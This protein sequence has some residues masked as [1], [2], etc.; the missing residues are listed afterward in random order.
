M[1]DAADTLER[2]ERKGLFLQEENR[3]REAPLFRENIR[4]MVEENG[5]GTGSEGFWKHLGT[6]YEQHG[7]L[8]EALACYLRL[9]DENAYRAAVTANYD[10]IPFLEMSYDRVAEWTEESPQICYLRGMY[11][12]TKQNMEGLEREIRKLE[13]LAENGES[14][15]EILL[16]LYYVKPDISLDTWLER[17]EA[18]GTGGQT[19][20]LYNI[21]GNSYT[22]LC[23]LRDLSG[24]FA[25][26]KKEE[27]RKARIWKEYLGKEEW[28]IY[29]L[30]QLDYYLMTERKDAVKDENWEVL[31]RKEERASGQMRLVRM[32]L[33]CKMQSSEEMEKLEEGLI[34]EESRGCAQNAEAISNLYSPWRGEQQKFVRWVYDSEREKEENVTEENYAVLGCKAKGYLLLNQHTRAEKIVSELIDHL[35]FYRRTR[36][37]AEVLFQQALIHWEEDRKK[38]ALRSLLESFTVGGACRYVQF[39]AD[40]GK[41]GNELLEEYVRWRNGN[42]PKRQHQNKKKYNYGNVLRMPMEEYLEV[43]LRISRRVARNYPDLQE[44]SVEEKLTMMETLI[45]QSISR[46]MTNAEICE[47][48]NLKLP[49]VK[50]HVYNLYK[51]LGAGSRVQAILK[52]KELGILN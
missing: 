28:D 8:K 20:R 52:G 24:L 5:R 36:F 37:L 33:F 25:C 42:L 13:K 29:L 34:R 9:E 43:L 17:L 1:P 2:L 49:T 32:Y 38:D 10:K 16:N 12:Y 3:W 35:R 51:K 48:L 39:Y 15:Q 11:C 30:A 22:F 26:A 27:N 14:V 41:K 44:E 50:S 19:F 45:F 40:Y 23:G 4:K 18:Y 46:G 7:A 47:E 21:I 31:Y 6:W